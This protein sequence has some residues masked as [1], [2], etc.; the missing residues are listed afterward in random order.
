MPWRKEF[1]E[2]CPEI[3]SDLYN[4]VAFPAAVL[5][6]A[7][8]Y[9]ALRFLE[10]LR[11]GGPWVL[12]AIVPDGKPTAIT[13]H[14]PDQAGAFVRKHNGKANLY[15]SVNPT[16]TAMSKK[17]AK[18]DIAAIE[19]V[20]AD[21]DPADGETS[22]AAKERY[23]EQ[24]VTFEPRPTAGVDSGNGIQCLW[25][26]EERIILGKP[27]KGKFSTEDQTKVTDVETRIA[28][29][30]LRLGSKAGTQNIDRIL[31]LPGTTNLPNAKKRK[32]GRVA[33]PTK[34]LWFNDV[35]YPLDAFPSPA[36]E[37]TTKDF[38]PF[39]DI[40]PT[41]QRL[42]ELSKKW[43]ALG[44]EGKGI[45]ENYDGDRSRAVMA[46]TCECV[47]AK[48]ADQVIASC[49]MQ[50]EIGQHIREQGNVE[51]AL[52]RTI[53][54]A[55]EF[56]AD[57]ELFKMNEQ[58]AVLPIGG[59]TR[60]A[61]WGEDPD[62]PGYWTIVRFSP[63]GDFKA[64]H[65][66][67]R[68]SYE[69]KDK[70]G[71]MESI[72]VGRGTWWI[73]HS[74]RRQYD[75]GMQFMP[76]RD[77][78]VVNDTLNLWNGFGFHARKPEG[79]SGA[80][81]CNLFLD[82]GRKIICSG[83]E[84]HFDYLMK[85][86]A[87]IAQKRT[88]SEIAVGLR[89]LEEGTGKGFW[90][91]ALNHLYGTHAQQV[92][93]SENVIGKHNKHLEIL[94]R[95][96]ADEALFVGDPRHRNALYG[97]I[98]EPTVTIEPKFVDSYPA[99][100]HLNVDILSNSEHFI[101]V[102]GTARRFFVPTVSPERASD[103]EYFRKIQQQ[104]N[105]GG[106]EALLYHLL[107]E[108][109]IRDFNV[110]AVPK[111]AALLQQAAYSRSGIDL[112]VE[113]ACSEGRVPFPHHQYPEVSMCTG[114]NAVGYPDAR[115]GFD[116]FVEHHSDRELGHMGILTVKRRLALEW[117]CVTG[118]RTRRQI[119][120]IRLHGVVWPPLSELRAKFEQKFG[121]QTWLNPQIT[122]WRSEATDSADARKEDEEAKEK[123][124]KKSPKGKRPLV[125]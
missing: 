77:E 36:E 94:L 51:R 54:R 9:I 26:L 30:M 99:Q 68:I 93:K 55:H 106:Y 37:G 89:T 74:G 6:W 98:T 10:Q 29:V 67:Y 116:Y 47:R 76:E 101:A 69:R 114:T 87:F 11:P 109:D 110:R 41:D 62:F 20:L 64:L 32:E 80:A 72:T 58:F 19:Y 27:V 121:P 15:Y 18:T 103:H 46:F 122:E 118:K 49:L 112:L 108:I 23:L 113:K 39:E 35:S 40:A 52:H 82:H 56:V 44:F 91:R 119:N 81:G 7:A 8:P 105:D 71:N 57:S 107:H 2:H 65:D 53:T 14:T 16:R 97:L 12:T 33:C 42:T 102:S 95:L 83:N 60:V 104:L 17:A 63:F 59:K 96:T 25:Q 70:K 85:R 13:A 88:R 123:E 48:I 86:E 84:E 45:L 38:G 66:K 34:V 100:N 92:Q 117:G 3:E 5:A 111:T 43:I 21:L 28:D 24:L 79:K 115:L 125:Y 50:W 1:A 4:V 90:C 124:R 61:T 75:G 120:G 22:D 73:G 78:D 31:R